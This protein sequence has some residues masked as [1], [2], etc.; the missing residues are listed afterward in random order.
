MDTF[1][2][3]QLSRFVI[4]TGHEKS[5]HLKKKNRS[6]RQNKKR[7]RHKLSRR[8]GTENIITSRSFQETDCR[9]EGNGKWNV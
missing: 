6:Y 3:R 2:G 9:T 8:K 1:K 4:H 7:G 5:D